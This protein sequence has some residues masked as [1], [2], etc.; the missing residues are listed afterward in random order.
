M[1]EETE[2]LKTAMLAYS[3]RCTREGR[4]FQQPSSSSSAVEG[5]KVVLRNI[6]GT[7]AT[8]KIS[9]RGTLSWED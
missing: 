5:D 7:L 3:K 2:L 8:Y 4:L 6:N 9:K 1:K